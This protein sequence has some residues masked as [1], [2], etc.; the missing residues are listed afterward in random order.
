MTDVGF[1]FS[2]TVMFCIPKTPS[3]LTVVFLLRCS[4][5]AETLW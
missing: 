2:S 3:V 5:V 1:K 4:V